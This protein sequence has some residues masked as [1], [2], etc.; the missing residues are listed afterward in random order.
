MGLTFSLGWLLEF[1]SR[2]A[3][4]VLIWVT[5]LTHLLSTQS[6]PDLQIFFWTVVHSSFLEGCSHL[7]SAFPR[8]RSKSPE[9]QSFEFAQNW[10]HGSIFIRT[11][12]NFLLARALGFG[13]FFFPALRRPL[14][15]QS[16]SR[17]LGSFYLY[18]NSIYLTTSLVT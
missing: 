10:D 5:E 11:F 2:A 3:C 9:C 8:G 6:L 12:L 7:S 1:Q 15:L 14:L 17:T 4:W 16:L 18:L 13:V